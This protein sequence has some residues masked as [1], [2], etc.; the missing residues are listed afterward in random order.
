MFALAKLPF[1]L[2]LLISDPI[3]ALEQKLE[4]IKVLG[5]A[6]A[7]MRADAPYEVSP[8]R[9]LALTSKDGLPCYIPESPAYR[10]YKVKPGSTFHGIKFDAPIGAEPE[11]YSWPNEKGNVYIL[12]ARNVDAVSSVQMLKNGP[13]DVGPVLN[14]KAIFIKTGKGPQPPPVDPVTPVLT[15]FQK[16]LQIAFSTDKAPVSSA[17]LLAALYR[18]AST[19]TVYDE[20]LKT[21]ESLLLEMQVAVKG[22]GIPSGSMNATARAIADE[23]N[24]QIGTVI[25]LD[26]STRDRISV[27]FNTIAISLEVIK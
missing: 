12:W 16:K 13:V 26:K 6:L 8:G 21:G 24:P 2:F 11:E 19:T 3:P 15:E 17:K 22:L 7:E 14:G 1:F 18:R 9:F 20:G 4:G 10:I 5:P 23:L 27:L 25:D